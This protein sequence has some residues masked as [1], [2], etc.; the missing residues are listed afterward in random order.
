MKKFFIIFGNWPFT[1]HISY[2]TALQTLI[3]HEQIQYIQR[4]K[5]MV[6]SVKSHTCR[7]CQALHS[8]KIAVNKAAHHLGLLSHWSECRPVIRAPVNLPTQGALQKSFPSGQPTPTGMSLAF[9]CI[10]PRG[11][12][13]YSNLDLFLLDSSQVRLEAK[14]QYLWAWLCSSV[15]VVWSKSW[16]Y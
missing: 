11:W 12:I 5:N 16:N 2:Y 3:V 7:T 10:C 9:P 6:C 1:S 4:V 15:H 13:S 8:V 14:I